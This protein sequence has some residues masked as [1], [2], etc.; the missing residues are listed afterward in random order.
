MYSGPY[1]L[2]SILAQK[3]QKTTKA[4]FVILFFKLCQ[5]GAGSEAAPAPV[6]A[7]VYQVNIWERS[8]PHRLICPCIFKFLIRLI[9]MRYNS[10]SWIYF[11]RRFFLIYPSV[12]SVWRH[13]NSGFGGCPPQN[14]RPPPPS[15]VVKLPRFCGIFPLDKKK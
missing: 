6:Q 13:Q 9:L 15:L 8:Y 11:L 5:G 10:F 4:F 2:L 1:I 7:T 12:S 3:L 14:G